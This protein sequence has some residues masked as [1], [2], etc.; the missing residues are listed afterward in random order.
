MHHSLTNDQLAEALQLTYDDTTLPA[1]P[2]RTALAREV[3]RRRE[4]AIVTRAD[5]V[6]FERTTQPG[7]L[8]CGDCTQKI[9]AT[10]AAINGHVC[11]RWWER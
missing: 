3:W 7:M 11:S 2:R 1:I 10:P 4:A 6:A 8:R 9:E 5:G